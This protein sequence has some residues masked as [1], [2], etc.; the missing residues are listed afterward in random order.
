MKPWSADCKQ[1][2]DKVDIEKALKLP[3]LVKTGQFTFRTNVLGRSSTIK[4]RIVRSAPATSEQST[5]EFQRFLLDHKQVRRSKAEVEERAL[6]AQH[7]DV[8][9]SNIKKLQN[10]SV[11][12]NSEI[13]LLLATLFKDISNSDAAKPIFKD[14]LE[15]VEQGVEY[16]GNLTDSVEKLHFASRKTAGIGRNRLTNN[17]QEYQTAQKKI[18]SLRKLILDGLDSL[19]TEYDNIE[20][21][22][23]R[24]KLNSDEEDDV[25]ELPV[26]NN[27][28]KTTSPSSSP[29]LVSSDSGFKTDEGTRS[30][31]DDGTV[32]QTD[33]DDEDTT[34]ET[35][36]KN[37]D[38]EAAAAKKSYERFDIAFA[39]NGDC[40]VKDS[41]LLTDF[42]YLEYEQYL[43]DVLNDDNDTENSE[44]PKKD[45]MA[46]STA[47][48]ELEKYFKQPRRWN[49][50]DID[51]VD[52]DN[53]S[54][55]TFSPI[56]VCNRV[57][58]LEYLDKTVDDVSSSYSEEDTA[59][60]TGTVQEMKTVDNTDPN[61]A[62][63]LKTM[64]LNIKSFALPSIK[65]ISQLL[66]TSQADSFSLEGSKKFTS[67]F[68][69]LESHYKTKVS[70]VAEKL[71]KH[72]EERPGF[73]NRELKNRLMMIK[74]LY[75]SDHP[76]YSVL[77]VDMFC[78]MVEPRIT[79]HQVKMA[80]L[81]L[82]ERL[83]LENQ[84]VACRA[85]MERELRKLEKRV[86]KVVVW[87]AEKSKVR[88]ERRDEME[89]QRLVCERLR[90][91]LAMM[92]EYKR[93]R[94]EEHQRQQL[95]QDAVTAAAR[96]TR[97]KQEQ[98]Q[99]EM[100]RDRI[101]QWKRNKIDVQNLARMQLEEE[102]R[103][104]LRHKQQEKINN[105]A[106]V[107]FRK[108]QFDK[109][110]TDQEEKRRQVMRN[111]HERNVRLEG[112]RR[113][114]RQRLGVHIISADKSRTT[115][116]TKA[117]KS[118][119]M[120]G[121]SASILTPMFPISTWNQD[122]LSRDQRLVLE[123]E[124]RERGL[125]DNEYAIKQILSVDPPTQPRP[126][127]KSTLTLGLKQRKTAVEQ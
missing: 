83:H 21:E 89:G 118:R 66:T 51:E 8:W 20:Q 97:M 76:N 17:R 116:L 125:L 106:R 62:A 102:L 110:M 119:L 117:A 57:T 99:R 77:W 79:P 53:L 103:V 1:Y 5:N 113:F 100:D 35:T 84:L 19:E 49:M 123:Q 81:W 48:I 122:D 94:A 114:A 37:E 2:V 56:A 67:A 87:M 39:D 13:E 112:L 43:N 46:P 93:L 11:T 9:I 72:E 42:P 64:D 86:R 104:V 24:I 34:S 27:V 28:E 69:A 22:L 108:V 50:F 58:P 80:D 38:D 54:P 95:A 59:S 30:S 6:L 36:L 23:S 101:L 41:D 33:L 109:K 14:I 40:I 12:L 124:L 4:Q 111:I 105:K 85:D 44:E 63:A 68:D 126:D 88:E 25:E 78:R 52:E 74:S 3:H 96:K 120:Q 127:T 75:P 15:T 91:E 61:P 31:G 55:V 7:K 32:S 16:R 107:K 65:S 90:D 47:M 115:Q 70:I 73:L 71:K 121:S 60:I 98:E 26:D 82:R 18:E 45:P 92:R 10:G 29:D